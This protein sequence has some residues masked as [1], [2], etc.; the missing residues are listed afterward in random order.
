LVHSFWR[1]Q[2]VETGGITVN[3]D[4]D[5]QAQLKNVNEY[6]VWMAAAHEAIWQLVHSGYLLIDGDGYEQIPARVRWY[7]DGGNW[8]LSLDDFKI[9]LPRQLRPSRITITGGTFLSDADLFLKDLNISNLHSEVADVTECIRCFRYELYLAA[10]V[11]LGRAAEGALTET[12]SAIGKLFLPTLGAIA[13]KLGTRVADNSFSKKIDFVRD[14]V[15]THSKNVETRCGIRLEDFKTAIL[16]IDIVRDARNAV[17]YLAAP[18]TAN[19]HE[20]VSTL[21]IGSVPALR[22]LYTIINTI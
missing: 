3:A 21:I 17:H 10:V 16:W 19:T 2:G 4:A 20:K 11:L 12:G 6:L 8:G 1:H 18:A 9:I 15:T 22:T 13:T 7:K 14:W 5:L